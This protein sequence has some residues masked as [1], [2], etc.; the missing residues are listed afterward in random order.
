M[1][2]VNFSKLSLPV[3][4]IILSCSHDQIAIAQNVP[5]PSNNVYQL[6]DVSP[7]DWA[8]EALRSLVERYDCLSGYSDNTFRS[9]RFLTRYEFAASLGKCLRQI[10]RLIAASTS[11]RKPSQAERLLIQR[12]QT[13]FAPEFAILRGRVDGVQARIGDLEITDFSTTTKLNGSVFLNLTGAFAGGD[14]QAEGKNSREL[15][16]PT[17]DVNN[18]PLRRQEV[19]DPNV[20]F[21][22]LVFLDLQTSF[23]GRDRLKTQLAVGNGNSVSNQFASAGLFNTYG[24]PYTLQTP[25]S[26]ANDVVIRELFYSFPIANNLNISVGPRLNWEEYFDTNRFTDFRTGTSTFNSTRSSQLNAVERGTGVIISWN[27]NEQ[28]ILQAG[29]LGNDADNPTAGLF[30]GTN[31]LTTEL[32]Y[33]PTDNLNFKF[34]YNY[35]HLQAVNGLIGGKVG[36]PIIGI[37]DDGLGGEL[38]NATANTFSL[39]ADWL[40]AKNF[41]IFGRYTYGIT[42]L[43]PK[44]SSRQNSDLE[45]QSLQLGL[46]FP[47]LFK[48]GALATL[49]YVIPFSVTNGREFLVSGGGDGGVQYELEASYY[50]PFTDNISLIPSFYL[51]GNPNNFSDNPNIYVGNF[52]FQ[53]D[54]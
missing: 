22:Y 19:D 30:G 6:R 11:K 50:Y 42:N 10:E 18:R 14:I 36:R 29:Y 2:T 52:R 8:Y 15:F 4:A 32:S 37:A 24:T 47:D 23:T 31:T 3:I 16:T 26:E 7:E 38:R 41:G 46:A 40:L 35:S 34:L 45:A 17:R 33:S 43:K 54:F 13:D 21:S 53:F 28:L 20:T 5:P 39:N 51:I 25:G 44:I 49:S 27:I 1:R 9:D 48:E 12:L